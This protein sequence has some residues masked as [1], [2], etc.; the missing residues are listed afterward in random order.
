[1]RRKRFQVTDRMEKK[2]WE[3]Q[4]DGA[5]L[6]TRFWPRKNLPARTSE[7]EMDSPE[8]AKKEMDRLCR[9]REDQDYVLI[10]SEDTTPKAAKAG[11]QMARL[12]EAIYAAPESVEP[13][14][15]YGDWLSE[16]ND[17]L[18]RLVAVQIK[19]VEKPREKALI[20]EEI[21]LLREHASTWLAELD[22]EEGFDSSWKWGFLDEARFGRLDSPCSMEP[23]AALDALFRLP[24]SRFLRGLVLGDFGSEE[25]FDYAPESDYS[26]II[27]GLADLT[28]PPTLKRFGI[29]PKLVRPAAAFIGS[30]EPLYPR[31]RKLESLWLKGTEIELG[32]V[33]LP[34]L[35][36]LELSSR[37]PST[38]PI[39]KKGKWK[40]LETLK[41]DYFSSVANTA[42]LSAI[43]DGETAPSLKRLT[44]SNLREG[45]GVLKP[46]AQSP[47]VKK[48]GLALL[49]LTGSDI[50][51]MGSQWLVD[52][53]KM[54]ANV[55]RLD[56]SDVDI[57]VSTVNEL[58]KSFGKRIKCA[59]GYA[60]D[61]PRRAEVDDDELYDEIEE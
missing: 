22:G 1:L 44:L 9:E 28:L 39:A 21:L 37:Y 11:A 56:L 40:K 43:L 7:R 15:V 32:D 3:V 50:S 19:R 38:E 47:I 17:P 48:G 51:E 41:L 2:V 5:M 13:Y 46:I 14:M 6:T 52:N 36:I 42:D 16:Q 45:E 58:R 12:E 20:D 8:A 26:E 34:E 55:Q 35:R 60:G 30:L 49:D 59:D 4:I 27:R 29:E 31:M 54:L 53:A 33:D 10:Q 23:L 57:P 24:T 61:R 18:G 25:E